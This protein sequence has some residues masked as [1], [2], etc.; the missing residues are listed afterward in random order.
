M[1][2]LKKA[3]VK[4]VNINS[5]NAMK[6]F[7]QP[8]FSSQSTKNIIRISFLSG[9]APFCSYVSSGTLNHLLYLFVMLINIS[10]CELQRCH[11]FE[12]KYGVASL[13]ISDRNYT[14]GLSTASVVY[15]IWSSTNYHWRIFVRI[16]FSTV[17][18]I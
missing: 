12:N 17:L 1:A 18:T 9:R 16:L 4:T 6:I 7:L 15:I 13:K 10:T 14:G 11:D 8:H 5:C 2:R 3:T